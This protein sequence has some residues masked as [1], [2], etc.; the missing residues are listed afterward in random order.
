MT[1]V[2]K[3]FEYFFF[4]PCVCVL[5]HYLSLWWKLFF[6]CSF[7][8]S[9]QDRSIWVSPEA[10]WSLTNSCYWSVFLNVSSTSTG[11][12]SWHHFSSI[13]RGWHSAY[14]CTCPLGLLM[15]FFP[16]LFICAA[17]SLHFLGEMYLSQKY[18]VNILLLVEMRSRMR[19]MLLLHALVLI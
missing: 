6:H 14:S 9:L 2:E 16:P 18:Q 17:A 11:R 15:G 1:S 8:V 5:V 12:S 4:P 10:V 19:S 13:C 7:L 3:P